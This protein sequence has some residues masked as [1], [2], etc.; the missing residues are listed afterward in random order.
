[1]GAIFSENLFSKNVFHHMIQIIYFFALAWKF[2]ERSDYLFC[3]LFS[4]YIFLL[5]WEHGDRSMGAGAWGSEQ[6]FWMIYCQ[7]KNSH[8]GGDQSNHF[9]MIYFQ[10][11]LF[12]V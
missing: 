2:G 11:V 4:D 1:M 8:E 3:S 10:N 6:F 12:I 7:R 5:G 9:W